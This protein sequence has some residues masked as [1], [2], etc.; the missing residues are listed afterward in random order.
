MNVFEGDNVD[1]FLHWEYENSNKMVEGEYIVL[2][3]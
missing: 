1:H 2:G 3:C